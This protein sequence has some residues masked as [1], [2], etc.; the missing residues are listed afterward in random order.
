M[1]VAGLALESF[2]NLLCFSATCHKGGA[3][4]QTCCAAAPKSCA[5][6]FVEIYLREIGQ[7]DLYYNKIPSRHERITK[8]HLQILM[9]I[10][11]CNR[12]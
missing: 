12:Y 7:C 6:R 3:S 5:P 1:L 2:S 11:R 9:D 8:M 10:N 4:A